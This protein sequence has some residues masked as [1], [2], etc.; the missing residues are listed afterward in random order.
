MHP[1]NPYRDGLDFAQL[2]RDRPSFAKFLVKGPSSIDFQDPRAVRYDDYISSPTF[3]PSYTTRLIHDKKEA[4]T[5]YPAQANSQQA[6]SRETLEY[7]CP[8]PKTDYVH[9]FVLHP[10]YPPIHSNTSP[11]QVPNRLDYI[12]WLQDLL[13]STRP[14]APADGYDPEREVTGLDIGVGASCIYPLLGSALRK[15]WKFIGTDINPPSLA[16]A[17]HQLLLNPHLLP[18]ITLHEKSSKDAFFEIPPSQSPSSST[19]PSSSQPTIKHIDFSMCNPPFFPTPSSAT[20]THSNTTPTPA[21]TSPST[22]TPLKPPKPTTKHLPPAM[23]CTASLNEMHTEGGELEFLRRMVLE[24]IHHHKNRPTTTTT[25]TT[26]PPPSSSSHHPPSTSSTL[27]L[28]PQWYTTLLGHLST[29]PPLLA[30]LRDHGVRNIAVAVF[31][32]GGKG[33]G[34]GGGSGGSGGGART[35]TRRWA[36]AYSFLPFRPARAVQ[37]HGPGAG[38]LLGRGGGGGGGGGDGVAAVVPTE[39]EIIVSGDEEGVEARV[40]RVMK[41]LVQFSGE[42]VCGWDE[43]GVGVGKDGDGGITTLTF[44]GNGWTNGNVWGRKF[45]RAR[46]RGGGEVEVGGDGEGEG[47]M[48]FRITVSTRPHLQQQEGEGE[49]EGEEGDDHPHEMDIDNDNDEM[50]DILQHNPPATKNT[51]H[52]THSTTTTTQNQ[53]TVTV[54]WIHGADPALFESFCG[55]VRRKV[56][57]NIT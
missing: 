56:L 13:D 32:Q 55:M 41:E 34:G 28:K 7:P 17:H 30:L 43:S 51:T 21:P 2:G 10:L 18:K 12:L 38:R 47:K 25:T 40:S 5:F 24:S 42:R 49:G 57:N 19:V 11:P 46:M 31:V 15:N 37:A 20:T 36:L 1:R 45:R 54:R 22:T 9:P 44:Q 3:P 8:S 27:L 23:T 4:H 50:Y 39:L 16:H 52:N 35:P 29:L 33:K 53:K 48:G 26:S 14:G 6:S